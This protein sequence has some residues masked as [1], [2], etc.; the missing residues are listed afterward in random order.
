MP[1][2]DAYSS[3]HLVLSHFVS[4]MWFNV[5]TNLS[6]TCLVS[7]PLNFEHPSVLLFCLQTVLKIVDNIRL[8]EGINSSVICGRNQTWWFSLVYWCFT[9]HA[10]IFKSYMWLHRCAGG[11]K[12][13]YLRSDSQRHRQFAGFFNPP[14]ASGAIRADYHVRWMAAG[15]LGRCQ[16]LKCKIAISQLFHYLTSN[17]QQYLHLTVKGW[18]LASPLR[19]YD[20]KAIWKSPP[21]RGRQRC[22]HKLVHCS[23]CNF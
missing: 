14:N 9:S 11:L 7:G 17:G 18:R 15:R 10:T 16:N 12:K 23:I 20:V 22:R 4:C 21:W 19:H 8:C 13:L 2:E 5:E 1:T 3:G 6:W